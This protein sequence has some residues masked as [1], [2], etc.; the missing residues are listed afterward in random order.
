MLIQSTNSVPMPNRGM[1]TEGTASIAS[2]PTPTKIAV[3]DAQA[4]N[5]V[6]RQ[7]GEK[8]DPTATQLKNA[9]DKINQSMREINS[10]LQ[11]SVDE[12]TQKMVVKVVESQTG[13][14]IKQFP[15]EEALAIAKAI[16]R[17]Q[18]GLLVQQKA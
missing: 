16:D 4:G 10:N 3:A 14:V 18:R 7:K 11:F 17:F 13:K 1:A 15:S 8:G 6:E 9:V 12:D 5:Q 2:A